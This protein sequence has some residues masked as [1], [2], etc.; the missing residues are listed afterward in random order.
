MNWA[1]WWPIGLLVLSNV[2]YH[3]CSKG[4]PA[5]LHPLAAI[6]VSY[7]AGAVF[8]FLVYRLVEPKGSFFAE[9]RHLNWVPFLLS[10]AIVGLETGAMCMYRAG[11][12]ISV[13]QLVM[14]T[15]VA[16]A[17]IFVGLLGFREMITVHKLI[18]I[19]LCLAGLFF[20]NR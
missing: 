9:F 3:V 16:I 6:S 19:A 8:S 14:S 11:W 20:I 4:M 5:D 10:V 17:L 7:L 15:L 1:M 2:V 18:G 13:G 12:E